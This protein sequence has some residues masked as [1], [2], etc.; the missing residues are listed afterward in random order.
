MSAAATDR[1]PTVRMDGRGAGDLRPL[2]VEMGYLEWAEG[3]ALLEMGK[4][5][6]LASASFESKVPRWLQGTGTGWVTA[7][8]AMLPRATA[9]RTS[10]EVQSGRPSGRTQ[11]IQR[12][13]GRSLRSITALDRMGET[14]VWIDCDVLQADGGTRTASITAG[15]LALAQ[16][17]GRLHD[18]GALP[19]GVLMDTVAAVSVGIVGDDLLLD[20]CYEEDAKAEVDFNVVMTGAGDLVEVQGTAEGAPFSREQLDALLDLASAGIQ[21]LTEFQR[22]TLGGG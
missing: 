1:D 12:L 14:S 9:V 10:R 17:V 11:E 15:Y 21:D 3:S 2:K 16:A 18:D 7:E 6:V 22:R 4:T 8:Y 5:R 19:D 20:L 13:V